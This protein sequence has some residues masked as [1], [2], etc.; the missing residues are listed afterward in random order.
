MLLMLFSVNNK[1]TP[2]FTF[3]FGYKKG[4]INC[5][6]LLPSSQYSSFFT[7]HT[8]FFSSTLHI[9][10]SRHSAQTPPNYFLDAYNK[11]PSTSFFHWLAKW[12]SIKWGQSVDNLLWACLHLFSSKYPIFSIHMSKKEVGWSRD[13]L[14]LF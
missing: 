5:C 10:S 8:P 14:A 6:L 11:M 9:Y 13:F 12:S 4:R 1:N 7:Q 3:R 2:Q